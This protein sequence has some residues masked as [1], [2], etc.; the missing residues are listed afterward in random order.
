VTADDAKKDADAK[1]ADKGADAKKATRTRATRRRTRA[2][3]K[4]V[5]VDWDGLAARVVRVPIEADNLNGVS[6]RRRTRSS[7]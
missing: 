5:V 2:K 6:P 7:T 1:D 3:A 4:P